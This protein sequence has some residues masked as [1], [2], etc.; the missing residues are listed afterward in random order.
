MP[1]PLQPMQ[2]ASSSGPGGW[3]GGGRQPSG[4]GT[5]TVIHGVASRPGL[6]HGDIVPTPSVPKWQRVPARPWPSRRRCSPRLT[7]A[8]VPAAVPGSPAG[9]GTRRGT[10]DSTVPHDW[11]LGFLTQRD[12]WQRGGRV[13][14][15][16]LAKRQGR[17]ALL[18]L[19]RWPGA[20]WWLCRVARYM[21]LRDTVPCGVVPRRGTA[22]AWR[23]QATPW[24]VTPRHVT[25]C[26]PRCAMCYT[27]PCHVPRRDVPRRVPHPLVCH[28]VVCHVLCRA[29]C[30]IP[31]CAMCH[32]AVPHP[33]PCHIPRRA[34]PGQ[35]PSHPMLPSHVC[36]RGQ[37]AQPGHRNTAPLCP[38]TPGH[39][40][41]TAQRPTGRGRR[42]ISF[43]RY[44][45]IWG[46][47]EPV[48]GA[49]LLTVPKSIAIHK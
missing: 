17:G 14:T 28:A 48:V 24:D 23:C 49:A 37:Q 32:C 21:G 47:H 41:T 38:Q 45:K 20:C 7:Q 26:V 35:V 3:L 19:R 25:R 27:V 42:F 16:A 40:D 39:T 8:A 33:V 15:E 5:V 46:C 44:T 29:M 12:R 13:P 30:H 34:A 4:G 2:A 22:L 6:L 36:W 31:S 11:V 10:S 1:S 18:W 9:T 43:C